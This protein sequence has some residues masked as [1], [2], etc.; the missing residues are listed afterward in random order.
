[1]I[2]KE[3]GKVP[4]YKVM[5]DMEKAEGQTSVGDEITLRE[6]ILKQR[7]AGAAEFNAYIMH[8]NK[9]LTERTL[10]FLSDFRRAETV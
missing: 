9:S 6:E 8:T 2:L 3:Y 4:S 7:D 5:V 1:M 10:Q